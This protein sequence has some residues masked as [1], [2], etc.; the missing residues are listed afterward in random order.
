MVGAHEGAQGETAR[1]PLDLFSPLPVVHVASAHLSEHRAEQRQVPVESV[2]VQVL[3]SEEREV[4][5][6]VGGLR[7]QLHRRA[8]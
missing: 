3:V 2:G 5:D 7:T 8:V 1:V 6:A 4:G